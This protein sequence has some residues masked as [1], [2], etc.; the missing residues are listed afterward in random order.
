[1]PPRQ[2][3]SVLASLVQKRMMRYQTV[4]IRDDWTWLLTQPKETH[5][6]G[7][8]AVAMAGTVHP[9][10]GKMPDLEKESEKR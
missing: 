9:A 1:V 5:S 10:S 3:G 2:G 7:G 4:H 6:T 8:I